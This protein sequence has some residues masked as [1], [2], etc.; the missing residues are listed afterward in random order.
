MLKLLDGGSFSPLEQRALADIVTATN[1]GLVPPAYL[2]EIVGVINP[3]RPFMA[4]TRRIEMPANGMQIIYPRIVTRPTIGEQTVQKSEVTSTNVS[5]DTATAN[6]RTFA[7][8]G[9]ISLQLLRRS[10]PAFLDFYLDLLA[11]AYAKGVN[12]AA[13]AALFAAGVSPGGAFDIET[14]AIPLGAA[15]SASVAATGSPARYDV[16]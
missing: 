3:A 2:D 13:L 6:V 10:S 12:S 8:A 9:D 14:G 15:F 11:E 4:S 5:T 16:A 1:A 7:G